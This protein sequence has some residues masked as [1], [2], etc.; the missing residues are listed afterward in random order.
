MADL[1]GG[2]GLPVANPNAMLLSG[3]I[4]DSFLRR[5]GD[6]PRVGPVPALGRG[7]GAHR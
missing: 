3:R 4:E 2:F 1:A 7:G 5:I 6:L